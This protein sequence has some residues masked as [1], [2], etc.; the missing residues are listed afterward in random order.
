M[1]VPKIL[2]EDRSVRCFCSYVFSI[3]GD[4]AFSFL[5][6]AAQSGEGG[7]GDP[8]CTLSVLASRECG[9]LRGSGNLTALLR[10]VLLRLIHSKAR[11]SHPFVHNFYY[12]YFTKHGYTVFSLCKMSCAFSTFLL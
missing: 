11:K 12:Y 9:Y 1:D 2:D 8:Q 4:P 3:N 5:T 7:S 6:A 10:S